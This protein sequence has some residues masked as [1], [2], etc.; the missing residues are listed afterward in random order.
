MRWVTATKN[1]VHSAKDEVIAMLR[2]A[3]RASTVETYQQA[4]VLLKE[5]QIWEQNKKFSN[6]FSS[7]WEPVH[8]VCIKQIFK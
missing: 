7:Q 6:W 5:S 8:K 4:I 1:N 3:A 2:Q